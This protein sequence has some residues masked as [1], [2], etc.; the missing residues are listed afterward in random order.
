MEDLHDGGDVR[1]A[2]ADVG[3]DQVREGLEARAR[4]QVVVLGDLAVVVGQ[5][6]RVGL[7]ARV[8]VLRGHDGQGHARLLAGFLVRVAD[9]QADDREGQLGQL[10]RLH[11]GARIG[12][13]GAEVDGAQAHRLG[14]HDYVLRGQ[15]RVLERRE[16]QV[17]RAQGLRGDAL[18]GADAAVAVQVGDEDEQVALRAAHVGLTGGCADRLAHLRVGDVQDCAGL[19]ERG[20]GGVARHVHQRGDLCLGEGLVLVGADRPVGELARNRLV[21]HA[22]ILRLDA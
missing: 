10:Q 19:Q 6:L 21:C 18:L 4:A 16:E 17:D 13:D 15:E 5:R 11:D 7:D 9:E 22:F 8:R 20:R 14:G 3:G 2:H 1:A 12:E